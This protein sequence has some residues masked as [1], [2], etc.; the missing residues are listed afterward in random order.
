MQ[1]NYRKT[2]EFANFWKYILPE[3]DRHIGPDTEIIWTNKTQRRVWSQPE[4]EAKNI[5]VPVLT[6]IS[7]WW[8]I[9]H[10]LCYSQWEI[11]F[12]LS[13]QPDFKSLIF[14]LIPLWYIKAAMAA[15]I[16]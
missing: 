5:A 7:S 8:A 6:G 11:Y 3:A 14:Q 10:D 16:P 2:W 15:V 1:K 4:V 13:Y 12:E 9:R